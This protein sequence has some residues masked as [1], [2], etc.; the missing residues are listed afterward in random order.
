MT[1]PVRRSRLTQRREACVNRPDDDRETRSERQGHAFARRSRAR[2]C[3]RDV[4]G[5]RRQ[6]G[7]R[8]GDR[9]DQAGSGRAD[10]DGQAATWSTA[11]ASPMAASSSRWPIPPSPLPATPTMS[12]SSRRRATSPSSGRASSATAGRDR[13]RNLAQRPIRHLRRARHGGRHRDRRVSRPF[14]HH[15]RHLAAGRGYR[16]QTEIN[17][18]GNARWPST[19]LEST[20][21]GYRAEMDD[22]ERASRDEI[23]ALQTKRLAWSLAHAYDNV[24]HYK[25]A[26]DKAGVHPSDFRQLV[27][28]RQIPV[29]GQDRSARQLPL[30]HVR[31]PPRKTGARPRLIRHHRQADRGRLYPGPISTCGRT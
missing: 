31:G 15:R 29:H 8:H 25:K 26:F 16:D 5:R 28:P 23:M 2:L 10:D 11:S 19:K 21:S 14:P 30:Q 13:A 18:Q 9:R 3:G 1:L 20:G 6:P 24:A 27:R 17:D 22:A 12:A 7:P 4:E